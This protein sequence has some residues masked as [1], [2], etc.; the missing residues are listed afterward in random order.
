MLL[1][2]VLLLLVSP[3]CS[4]SVPAQTT[5][6]NDSMISGYRDDYEDDP[7]LQMLLLQKDDPESF[8][9][10]RFQAPSAVH[11][12][13]GGVRSAETSFRSY[14]G[15][16]GREGRVAA[17][18]L[19]GD[20][21][22]AESHQT[23]VACTPQQVMAAYLSGDLQTQWNRDT[24]LAC[25]IVPEQAA[26]NGGGSCWRQDLVLR[27]QRII[28]RSTGV[29]RYSQRITVDQIGGQG[30]YC[31][32]VQLDPES[33]ATTRKP[34]EAL[35][36][37]IS[38]QPNSQNPGDVDLYAAGLMKVNRSVVPKLGPLFDASGI[39]G[40]MAGKGTL[41]LAAH[42]GARARARRSSS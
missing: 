27:S 30:H 39:A 13:L 32:T 12:A 10:G 8:S 34:F 42:F 7:A 25:G 35:T 1:R 24:V 5:T 38:L 3:M 11:R 4:S 22:L 29:M 23:A 40:S 17:T 31:V 18:R 33:S 15:R 16:D 28:A 20:W 14:R 9:F 19:G 6:W 41:W 36:V 37:Y 2:S 26:R 21:V